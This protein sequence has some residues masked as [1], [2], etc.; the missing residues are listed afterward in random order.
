MLPATL[1]PAIYSASNRKEYQ[2]QIYKS[3]L[4]IKERPVSDAEN[5]TAICQPTV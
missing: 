2:R 1:D 5:L 4:L 3:F